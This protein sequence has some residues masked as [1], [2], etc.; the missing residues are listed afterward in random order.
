MR[1]L[2]PTLTPE[3]FV[4]TSLLRPTATILVIDDEEISRGVAYRI[5]SEE[6]YRVLEAETCG[7]TFDALRLARGRVDLLMIDVVLPQCDGFAVGR[8]VL[9][10]WPDQ[11]ILYTSAAPAGVLAARGLTAGHVGFLSKPYTRTEVLAKVKE[12]LEKVPA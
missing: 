7:E 5:L 8:H 9:E 3:G 11:G 1:F 10:Q 6:G 2:T 4:V 12:M